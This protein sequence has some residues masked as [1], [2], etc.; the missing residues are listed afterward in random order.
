MDAAG[1]SKMLTS[2]YPTAQHCFPENINFQQQQIHYLEDMRF[3][4]S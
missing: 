1:L 2:F 4:G 3:F